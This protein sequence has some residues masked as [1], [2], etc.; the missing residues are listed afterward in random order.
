MPCLWQELLFSPQD[1]Y[2]REAAANPARVVVKRKQPVVASQ[3][4][5]RTVRIAVS[6]PPAARTEPPAVAS[7]PAARTEPRAAKKEQIAVSRLPAA[8]TEPP[9]ASNVTSSLARS[10]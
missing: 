7:P 10:P 9:A 6:R 2:P 8:R 3:P 5:A 4:A 1:A